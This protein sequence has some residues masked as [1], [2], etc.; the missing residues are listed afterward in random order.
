MVLD[1]RDQFRQNRG[2]FEMAHQDKGVGLEELLVQAA[3]GATSRERIRAVEQLRQ[4]VPAPTGMDVLWGILE[5]EGDPRRLVAAR[6]LGYH[7]RW[8]SSQSSLNRLL[9]LLRRE[10][11][12]RVGV[13]LAWCLRQR[14]EIQEF[15]LHEDDHVAREAALGLPV[16]RD[17]LGSLLQA[18]L[19][20]RRAPVERILLDKLGGIHPPLVRGLIEDLL[21]RE[22]AEYGRLAA[23]CARLPQVALFEV[24]LDKRGAPDWDPH[25]D[26]RQAARSRAWRLLGCIALEV[27]QRSPSV[28]LLQYLFKRSGEDEAFAWRHVHFM[29]AALQSTDAPAGSELL[30][31]LERLTEQASEVKVARMAQLLVELDSRLEGEAKAR[32]AALL[33]RWK[34][35]SATLNLKIYHLQ[36]GLA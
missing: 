14:N 7:R 27:L 3:C 33:E 28:E 29:R 5:M 20:S 32:A 1:I 6:M 12:P 18:L 13:G 2:K 31:D 23:L 21:E 16:N 17:T 36:Q 25:Q 30:E 15:L 4:V 24:L 9:S 22:G 26:A 35:R 8:L 11:D 34:S 19:E 10:R